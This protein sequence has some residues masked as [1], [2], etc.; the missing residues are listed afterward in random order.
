MVSGKMPAGRAPES[1]VPGGIGGL[2]ARRRWKTGPHLVHYAIVVLACLLFDLLSPDRTGLA[3]SSALFLAWSAWL[4][5]REREAALLSLNPVVCYQAWQTATLGL[6]PLYI[7][8]ST[9]SGGDVGFE[10]GHRLS[11]GVV[12]YGHALMVLG[13]CAFYAGMKKFQ[14]REAQLQAAGGTGASPAALLMAASIGVVFHWGNEMITPYVGS[15]VVQLGSL[16]MAALCMVAL[17]PPR[18]LRRSVRVQMFVLLLG[19]VGVLLLNAR[20]NSKMDLIF[21][22]VP[23]LWWALNRRNRKT[24]AVVGF[25]LATLYLAVIAPLV[26]LMRANRG[27]EVGPVRTLNPGVTQDV[28]D[29]MKANYLSSPAAYLQD[30]LDATMSRI[31]DPSAA[32]MAFTLVQERGFLWGSGLSYVAAS[33]IP[34]VLWHAK[35]LADRGRDFSAAIGMA[36]DASLAT[37]STGETSAGELYW[38]FGWPGVIIGMYVL[39]GVIAGFWWRAAGADPCRGLLEM[40]AYTGAMLSFVVGTGAAAGTTLVM[41][42]GAGLFWRAAIYL[43]DKG[44]SPKAQDRP[45]GSRR[46][47]L[48]WRGPVGPIRDARRSRARSG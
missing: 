29:S 21:S 7:A 12:A 11:F 3:L 37:T 38:N 15:T 2:T 47:D 24:L 25:A 20:R 19:A 17:N 44:F 32:G 33:F 36:S 34:R 14:P 23:V 40:T 39:G 6:A 41:A 43:R 8:L 27:G 4:T 9:A 46:S 48:K 30:Q 5:N 31:C 13:S 18:A 26:N 10:G 1:I 42:V 45:G 35:P 28:A 16:P 22:F